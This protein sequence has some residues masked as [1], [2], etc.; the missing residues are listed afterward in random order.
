[1]RTE[2]AGQL[3]GL[4]ASRTAF[5]RGSLTTCRLASRFLASLCQTQRDKGIALTLP[6]DPETSGFTLNLV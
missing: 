3:D 4:L 1:M 2:I 6:L 5:P